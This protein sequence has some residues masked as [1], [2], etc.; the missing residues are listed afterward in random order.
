MYST[1][2]KKKI[3]IKL[4][5]SCLLLALALLL[6]SLGSALLP[7]RLTKREVSAGAISRVSDA[8]LRLARD[9]QEDVRVYWLCAGGVTEYGMEVFLSRYEEAGD[10]I[11]VQ[12]V[13]TDARPDFVEAYVGEGASL[14]N[15]S[16]IVESD[17][18]ATVLDYT[19]LYLFSNDMLNSY[20]GEETLL[21]YYQLSVYV[22]QAGS[23]LQSSVTSR[24]FCGE[25]RLSAALEYVTAERIP[26][27]YLLTGH[28]GLLPSELSEVLDGLGVT[29]L[30]LSGTGSVPSDADC[31]ILYAP[32]QDLS[33]AEA[34]LLADYLAAGGSFLLVTDP[35]SVE[36]CPL[37]AGLAGELYGLSALSGV[38]SDPTE[39]YHRGS[40]LTH[41]IPVVNTLQEVGASFSDSGL[42]A[43]MPT[44]HGIQISESLPRGVTA[45]S[46]LSSSSAAYVADSPE[47]VG[48]LSVAVVASRPVARSDGSTRTARFCWFGSGS[49]FTSAGAQDSSYGNYYLFLSALSYM[50]DSFSSSFSSVS[51]ICLDGNSMSGLSRG[52][53]A[54]WSVLLI[55]VIPGVFVGVG[56]WRR[57]RASARG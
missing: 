37:A 26:H 31:L 38:V 35:D 13:D 25:A 46:L 2:W 18:R 6:L 4:F 22:E 28:G 16:L 23:L 55:G 49:A 54:A 51:P 29:E 12:I 33:A 3:R 34:A 53:A 10:R 44:S 5:L 32:T 21:T 24:Y 7:W 43:T 57:R 27:T 52:A 42:S 30:S 36:A 19:D 39:G 48:I 45:L 17:R 40:D 20:F 9:I 14:A 15:Y 56:I 41:L 8:S 11:T 1:A 47:D 50:Q